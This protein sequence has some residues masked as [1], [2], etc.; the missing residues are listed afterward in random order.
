[1][2]QTEKKINFS[3][4]KSLALVGIMAATVECGKLAL[5]F[6][7]NIEVVTLLLALFGYVFG[8]YGVA[9]AVVFVCIE[10][11]IYGVGSWIITYILYWPAVAVVFMILS[12]LKVKKIWM[13]TS[14]AVLMTFLFGVISSVIDSAFYLGINQHYLSNLALYYARGLIFYIL[15]I[16]CNLALFLTVFNY[17]SGKLT[18]LKRHFNL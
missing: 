5:S 13:L 7:P 9:A 4:A 11:L 6:L 10:P 17:L 8:W 1:M 3:G 18:A 12:R 16:A 15:Q 14:V 2:M